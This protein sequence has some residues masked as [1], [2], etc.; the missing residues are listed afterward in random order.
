VLT[1]VYGRVPPP[2]WPAFFRAKSQL[3][4]IAIYGQDLIGLGQAVNLVLGLRHGRYK[5]NDRLDEAQD[6]TRF[7]GTAWQAGLTWQIGSGVSAYGGYN[8]G[9]NFEATSGARSAGGEPLVPETSGQAEI[10]FRLAQSRVKASASL[11]HIVRNN[12]L[13]ADPLNPGFSIQTGR[14][15]VSGLEIEGRWDA[16]GG[17]SV[18]AGYIHFASRIATSTNG[19]E[20]DPV[21][22][23][24]AN[25]GNI[26]VAWAP[27]HFP[28]LSLR[29]GAN[30]VGPR[31]FSNARV[32]IGPKLLASDVE[33]PGYTVAQFG[34]GYTH[35]GLRIDATLTNA[36]DARYF[37]RGGPPQ[38]VYAG[39]PRFFSVSIS[40]QF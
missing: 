24:P 11:F 17:V 39:E 23:V 25:Q 12:V 8:T 3:H 10:G 16:G 13:T 32:P 35:A 29:T 21:A 14:Q 2:P 5:S 18:Q 27:P 38:L 9:Y 4:G 40:S 15:R 19:D 1:P 31:L 26:F 37:V 6:R 28:G 33:L 34:A 7:A 20:G 36:F 22:D 30:Y